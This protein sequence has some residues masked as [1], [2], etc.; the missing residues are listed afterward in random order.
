V[1]D[2][3]RAA[4]PSLVDTGRRPVG[5]DLGVGPL[6]FGCWRFVG[7]D[8]PAGQELVETALDLGM[9]LIDTADIYG[10]GFGGSGFGAAEELL[11]R[12]LAASPGLRDRMVLATKGGIRPGVPYDSSGSYL[13]AACEGSLRRLGV[14]TV[15]LY[16]VHRPDLLAHP[17]EIAEALDALVTAGKVRAVGVSNHT[18]AQTEALAHHLGAPVVA[19]QPE[20][21]AAHLAP[22]RD[23]TGDLA[24]GHGQAVLAWSPLAGGRLAGGDAPGVRPEL[25]GVLDEVAAREEVDRASVA[26]AFVLALPPRPVAI[27][28]TQTPLRLHHAQRALTVHLDRTDCYRII[29]ASEGVPLP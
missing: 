15:D 18:P 8:V 27:L 19:T 28:G 25:L 11:G 22:L 12:V 29:E 7:T 9:D 6:A 24:M 4:P 23:G 2:A 5:P 16:Q 1:T 13:V 21:S 26:L 3:D 14:D 10:L 17:A 20:L